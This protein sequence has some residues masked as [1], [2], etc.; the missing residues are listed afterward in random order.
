MNFSGEKRKFTNVIEAIL[1]VH[2]FR[3][4]SSC[5]EA[6]YPNKPL[7]LVQNIAEA[8]YPKPF[9]SVNLTHD[10]ERRQSDEEIYA[11][12]RRANCPTCIIS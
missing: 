2:I 8:H 10:K 11:V 9:F 4:A 3:V 12:C 6:L 5:L 1:K 7:D